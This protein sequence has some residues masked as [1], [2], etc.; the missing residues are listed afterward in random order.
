MQ[1]I[2]LWTLCLAVCS[3][4]A[5]AQE[6]LIDAARNGDKAAVQSLVAKGANVDF[7]HGDG[8]TALH[9]AAYNDDVDT[10]TLLTRRGAKID[11]I[12]RNGSLT[13]LMIA[14]RNGSG[15]TAA[16]LL[17]GGA[18]VRLRSQD[19]ATVL[20]LAAAAGS[21]DIVTALLDRGAEIDARDSAR[22]Q[23]ALMFAA[24]ANR[25]QVVKL[26]ISRGAD[27]RMTSTVSAP[28]RL[29]RVGQNPNAPQA[30]PPKPTDAVSQARAERRVSPTA[31]GGWTALHF[32]ARQGHL[33]AARTL[34]EA[35][36]NVNQPNDGD[37][38]TPLVTAIVNGHYDDAKLLLEKGA[39]PNLVNDDG[40][41]PLYATIDMQFAPVIWQPNPPTDQEKTSYLALMT[42]L[43]D[44][45]ADPNARLKKKLWFRPSDHD[46]AWT[47]FAGTTAFW[48][49]AFAADV[50]AM[51]LLV[52]R[53]AD[54]KILSSEGVT[55]LMAA[56]GLG[57]TGN[58]HR[59]VPGGWLAAVKYSLELG[60]DLHAKDIF[61][62]TALHAAAY[63]GDNDLVKFLVEKGARLDAVT[64]FG[65]NVTDMANGFVAFG[66]NPAEHPDTVKLL[67]SL[68]GPPPR[69]GERKYCT[70]ADL[71]CPVIS[72]AR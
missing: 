39:D 38:T 67:M 10:A 35:G 8:M 58:Q 1:R 5:R 46:D 49:A 37:R 12:T 56:A 33:D 60:G 23:T 54:P 31:L 30:A 69:A 50:E 61:G 25:T 32:A 42:L 71:N 29:A 43:L 57:W 65:D 9:W 22:G 14:A 72:A 18:N 4:S 20:M 34:I 21:T 66:S 45:G 17:N 62:Y 36:A 40:L 24:A 28:P 19:G 70:A 44:K 64:I 15:R 63:R 51:R 13:P 3:T 6:P 2:I 16:V 53:G 55:T 48:R 68:G 27:V 7:A 59:T 47:G 52:S 26:L 41:A 11:P